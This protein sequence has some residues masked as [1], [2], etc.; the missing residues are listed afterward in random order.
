MSRRVAVLGGG[1]GWHV[2]D[3]VRAGRGMGIEVAALDFRR[4]RAALGPGQGGVWS[5][6]SEVSA[7][8]SVIVRSMPAGTLEQVIFRMD[9]LHRL[10]ALGARVLNRPRA[11]ECCIDKYLTAARLDSAGLPV[12]PGETAETA[13][14]AMAAFERLGGDV[15]LKPIFGSEGKGVS[16]IRS[17]EEAATRFAE[18]EAAGSVI[19]IQRF[20]DHPGH[21]LRLFVLGGSV[22]AAM[23]RHAPE[24]GSFVTNVARGGRAEALDPSPEV[25]RLAELAARAAGAEAAGVDVVPDRE[26]RHWVLEVNAVPGWLALSAVTGVDVAREVLAYA[27]ARD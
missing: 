8:E 17:R 18:L 21:D 3:L 7:F 19:H 13:D 1:G 11:L 4:I 15:V 25:R 26:G 20:I 6:S 9:A 5:G 22:L 14:G 23:R 16:R 10:E 27:A 24:D 2:K 12:P